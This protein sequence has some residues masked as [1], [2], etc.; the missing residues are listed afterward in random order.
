MVF[1]MIWDHEIVGSI[2][3]TL[4]TESTNGRQS[5]FEPLNLGSNPSSVI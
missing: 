5:G 4:T 2:P 3:T 1:R